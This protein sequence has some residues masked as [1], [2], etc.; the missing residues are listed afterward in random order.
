MAGVDGYVMDL[1]ANFLGQLNTRLVV[2]LLI[3]KNAPQPAVRLNPS[4]RVGDD[5]VVMMTQFM[6]AVPRIS[7]G[8]FTGNLSDHRDEIVNAVDFL[9]QGF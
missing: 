7:L 2:P 9:M 3:A 8:T 6:A 4:F 1:Q 5:E